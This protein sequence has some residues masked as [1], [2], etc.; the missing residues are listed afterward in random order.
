MWGMGIVYEEGPPSEKQCNV[1][2]EGIGPG[3]RG[4]PVHSF[5]LLFTKY[6]LSC[7]YY[8]IGIVLNTGM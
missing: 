5:T 4:I 3:V 7:Y 8:I 2:V 1:M 6:L